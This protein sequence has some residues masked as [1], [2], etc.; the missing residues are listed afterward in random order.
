MKKRKMNNII[1]SLE[2]KN[3]RLDKFLSTALDG[4]SRSK[5]QSLIEDGYILVNNETKNVSYKL[6]VGDNIS[7]KEFPKEESDLASEAIDLDIVYEDDYLMVI[8]KPVGLVVHPGAGNTHGTLANGLKAYSDNLSD[9]NGEFRP[10]I[11][12]RIDKDTSGLLVIAKT[13]EAHEFLSNQ[14]VDHTLGRKYMALVVGNFTENEG[15]IIAPIGRDKTDR[16]KM[17]VDLKNGKEAVTY[18]KVIKRFKDYTLVECSL[19]TGRTHQIRV[20]MNYINHPIVGDNVYGKNNR[21]LYDKGQLLTA[22]KIAF[23]HPKDKK[24]RE[25]EVPLPKYFLDIISTLQ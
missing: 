17:S 4:Y 25:Y 16:K 20:H 8:N 23:I 12:H 14:L 1:V 18:F 6:S 3:E 9:I 2:N 7:F 21:K 19:E 5:I 11:V 10:G 24:R 22:Y 13:N 15:K